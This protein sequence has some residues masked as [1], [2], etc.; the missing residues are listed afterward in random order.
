MN[1][2]LESL[3]CEHR[4]DLEFVIISVMDDQVICVIIAK[5]PE[6]LPD[7]V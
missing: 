7:V 4:E 6:R 1:I 5:D 2:Y 3:W